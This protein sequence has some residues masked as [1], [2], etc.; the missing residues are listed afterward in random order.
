MRRIGPTVIEKCLDK[1]LA[2]NRESRRIKG[3]RSLRRGM[4]AKRREPRPNDLEENQFLWMIRKTGIPRIL[5]ASLLAFGR[6]CADHL[7][8]KMTLGC[9][10]ILAALL[11]IVMPR[12]LTY[13]LL[14]PI[15]RLVLGNLYPAY[16]SYKAVRTKNVKE[17]VSMIGPGSRSVSD[18]SLRKP[19][20]FFLAFHYHR[21]S[22]IILINRARPRAKYEQVPALS[23]SKR[24]MFLPNR[25]LC[26]ANVYPRRLSWVSLLKINRFYLG[27]TLPLA[28]NSRVAYRFAIRFDSKVKFAT[29]SSAIL[30][31]PQ[32]PRIIFTYAREPRRQV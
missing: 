9:L 12:T 25:K 23:I 8:K 19:E 6:Y 3:E 4:E 27:R 14:Y 10:R 7:P 31:S 2:S 30:V 24:P 32:P 11:V 13:V 21:L 29:P 15:F 28:F 16:A 5:V 18:R 22:F 20:V 26:S 17:Y 1:A